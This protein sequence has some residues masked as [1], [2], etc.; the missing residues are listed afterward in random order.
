V[1][2]LLFAKSVQGVSQGLTVTNFIFD[3]TRRP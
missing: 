3:G 2:F 1:S